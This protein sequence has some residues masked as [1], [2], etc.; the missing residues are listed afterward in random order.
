M[1]RPGRTGAFSFSWIAPSFSSDKDE[2][3]LTSIFIQIDL[4]E[5]QPPYPKGLR[6]MEEHKDKIVLLHLKGIGKDWPRVRC[7][8]ANGEGDL[9]LA[10]VLDKPEL[11]LSFNPGD[12]H[13]RE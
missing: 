9:P 11:S 7:A 1:K 8:T 5:T 4:Y 2:G 13:R 10:P 6:F 12:H 3:L